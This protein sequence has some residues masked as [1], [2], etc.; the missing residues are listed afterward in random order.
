MI[1]NLNKIIIENKKYIIHEL[2]EHFI[3]KCSFPK[4]D[5]EAIIKLEKKIN[6]DINELI[7]FNTF[8][9]GLFHE[10]KKTGKFE[11]FIHD[12]SNLQDEYPSEKIL[13]N[14]RNIKMIFYQS[15]SI[16]EFLL[17]LYLEEILIN[18]YDS[19][20]KYEIYF[21]NKKIN[22]IFST[23][24]K[25]FG[26]KEHIDSYYNMP[27]IYETFKKFDNEFI[28]VLLKILKSFI[29]NSNKNSEKIKIETQII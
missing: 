1:V 21:M 5:K 14:L 6:R 10:M 29:C 26:I 13:N 22:L 2:T 17:N 28:S 11:E 18:T 15:E 7:E 25:W 23:F 12:F 16:L 9:R 4:N 24:F 19:V 8:I 20:Q 3:K 27:E